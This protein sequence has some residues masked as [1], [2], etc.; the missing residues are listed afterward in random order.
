M[1]RNTSRKI[2]TARKTNTQRKTQRLATQNPATNAL[3]RN[4]QAIPAKLVS[5]LR[6]E[7][8][9]L[10][11][12]EKKLR[13]ELKHT[14]IQKKNLKKQQSNLMTKHKRQPSANNKKQLKMIGVHHDKAQKTAQVLSRQLGQIKNE[15]Q[16]IV[17]KQAKYAAIPTLLSKFNKQWEEKAKKTVRGTA[18]KSH[19]KA[20]RTQ[21]LSIDAATPVLENASFRISAARNG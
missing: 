20:G 1:R 16:T 12:Q 19:K 11:Q 13:L 8:T 9:T 18:N 7:A 3:E 15:I 21:K 2:T 6:R 4:F 17:T 10:T 14:D 5:Q